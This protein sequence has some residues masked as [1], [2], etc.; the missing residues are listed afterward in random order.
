MLYFNTAFGN[1]IN[2][3]C[4]K[5]AKTYQRFILTTRDIILICHVYRYRA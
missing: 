1:L 4:E 5:S 2:F 3:S